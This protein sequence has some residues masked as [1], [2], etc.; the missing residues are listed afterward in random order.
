MVEKLGHVA[1]E[2]ER[3]PMLG[4]PAEMPLPGGREYS[5][6]TAREI[7]CAVREIAAT[8]FGTAVSVLEGRR[9]VL[10]RGARLLLEK[11]TLNEQDLQM[12]RDSLPAADAAG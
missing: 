12:L 11:E 8:A 6:D 1:Y 7:D 5:E 4:G 9:A 3:A 2:T 10:E